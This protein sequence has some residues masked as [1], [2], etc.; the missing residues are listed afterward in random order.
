MSALDG[1]GVTG[2]TGDK[3]RYIS[4]MADD[5]LDLFIDG[6]R[7]R[8][9]VT[10]NKY[11]ANKVSTANRRLLKAFELCDKAISAEEKAL[12]RLE[13]AINTIRALRLELEDDYSG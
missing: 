4:D 13:K 3:R 5:E 11:K 1:D 2:D 6:I 9:M 10:Y 12:E 8:R 7:A